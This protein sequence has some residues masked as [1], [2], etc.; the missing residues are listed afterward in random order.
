M[1]TLDDIFVQNVPKILKV[2]NHILMSTTLSKML[3]W[4]LITTV[5][6]SFEFIFIISVWIRMV[7]TSKRIH[8][9]NN[10]QGYLMLYAA[11]YLFVELLFFYCSLM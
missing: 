5:F 6:I 10:I 4:Y 2:P 1:F 8:V 9:Q 3:V 7:G 11:L